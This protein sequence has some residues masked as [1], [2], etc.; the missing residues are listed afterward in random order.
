MIMAATAAAGI[1]S[2]ML[3]LDGYATTVDVP[4]AWGEMDAFGHVNTVVYFR[5]FETARIAYLRAIGFTGSD[6]HGRTAPVVGPILH[7]THC[8]FRRPL[9]FPDS[10]RVGARSISVGADRF[11]MEYAIASERAGG[12]AADGGGIVVAYDYANARRADLPEAVRARILELDG[13]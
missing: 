4:V 11:T 3:M 13:V 1:D 7:S 10:V 12:I 6:E 5:Y 9:A 2:V 8:R